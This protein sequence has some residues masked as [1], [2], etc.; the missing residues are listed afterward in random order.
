SLVVDSVSMSDSAGND[1]GEVSSGVVSAR[2]GFG[3]TSS[4]GGAIP[5]AVL[6]TSTSSST[7]APAV[8][9]VRLRAT[10]QPAASGNSVV[11]TTATSY[12]DAAAPTW[13]LTAASTIS[14][15]VVAHA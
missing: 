2:L 4:V 10:I 13:P 3:A 11:F 1:A 5:A 15:P 14:T 6:G 8:V 12:R 7:I 9:T